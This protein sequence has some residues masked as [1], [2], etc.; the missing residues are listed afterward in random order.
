MSAAR[1]AVEHPIGQP[2]TECVESGMSPQPDGVSIWFSSQHHRA[3]VLAKK[4]INGVEIPL[5]QR[6]DVGSQLGLVGFLPGVVE[7]LRG[8]NGREV[9]ELR[10]RSLVRPTKK[11]PSG[12][13]TAGSRHVPPVDEGQIAGDVLWPKAAERGTHHTDVELGDARCLP[14]NALQ[15]PIQRRGHFAYISRRSESSW[16]CV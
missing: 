8:P 15:L 16:R 2:Q 3:Q 7:E 5:S 9:P 12:R 10:R 6:G 13:L 1:V 14:S 4:G 11:N